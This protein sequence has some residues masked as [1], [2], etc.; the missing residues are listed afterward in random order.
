MTDERRPSDVVPK[1]YVA[2]ACVG[3]V[4]VVATYVWFQGRPLPLFSGMLLIVLA[5][6]GGLLRRLGRRT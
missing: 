5:G 1:I 3:F 4:L 6:F 2:M